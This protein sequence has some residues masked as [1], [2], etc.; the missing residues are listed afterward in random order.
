MP[1]QR[2]HLQ[3]RSAAVD[4]ADDVVGGFGPDEPLRVS[5][6]V[7]DVSVDGAF[8]LRHAGKHPATDPLGGDLAEPALDPV[9][10]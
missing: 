9:Q 6:V 2:R 4:F 8:E 5:I 1:R 3:N 7:F 10:P